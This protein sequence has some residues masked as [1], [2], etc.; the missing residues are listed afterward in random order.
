MVLPAPLGPST[1]TRSP[2]AT[3]EVD[4]VEG[5]VAVRIRV[6]QRLDVHRRGRVIAVTHA[7]S[8][9]PH[10]G[11]GG[12]SAPAAHCL[13]AAG[14]GAPT[15]RQLGHLAVEAPREHRQV[16]PLAAFVGPEEQHPNAFGGGARPG[17]ASAASR[18]ARSGPSAS[19]W[20]RPS[21]SPHSGSSTSAP[22]S[23]R[24]ERRSRLSATGSSLADV[25]AATVSE[26]ATPSVPLTTM[27]HAAYRPLTESCSPATSIR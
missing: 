17:A 18:R 23:P 12:Q 10:R 8:R 25:V 24:R 14:G 21:D 1:A 16:H 13:G 15:D 19:D 11:H 4:A 2:G 7:I 27:P 3:V 6:A 9:H 5:D 26:A 22:R 20:P